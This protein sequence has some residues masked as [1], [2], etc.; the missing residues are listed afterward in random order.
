MLSPPKTFG[1]GGTTLT[2]ASVREHER[3]KNL[4][5]TISEKNQSREFHPIFVT[6]VFGIIDVL[7]R[8]WGQKVKVTAGPGIIVG[9]NSSPSS[10]IYRFVGIFA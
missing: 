10:S 6:N 7:I 8:F 3:P 4:A 5:N 9:L 2:G 1:A